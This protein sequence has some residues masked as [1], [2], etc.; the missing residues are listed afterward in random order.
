MINQTDISELYGLASQH[1]LAKVVSIASELK[2][3]H[4]LQEKILSLNEFAKYCGLHKEATLSFLK[5]LDAHDIIQLL[6]E[7][8]VKEGRLCKYLEHIRAPHLLNSYQT[9]SNLS[10]SLQSNLECY[11]IEMGL[12]FSQ[13]AAAYPDPNFEYWKK[14]SAEDWLIPSLMSTYDFSK[15]SSLCCLVDDIYS[16]TQILKCN[17][18]QQGFLLKQN[19]NNIKN[20]ELHFERISFIEGNMENFIPSQ[21]EALLI[22]RGFLNINKD[23][24][25]NILSHLASQCRTSTL[26]IVDFFMPT[27]QHID[28]KISSIAAL[29]ILTCLG[30]TLRT[31]EEWI[32]LFNASPYRCKKFDKLPSSGQLKTVLPMFLYE[33]IIT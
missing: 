26:I 24:I 11:S 23:K 13:H 21:C 17:P 18:Q 25:L 27:S 32:E 5:V 15:F 14:K 3:D 22:C 1:I 29:N 9:I 6:P 12:N 2:I 7:N 10:H 31:E 16:L 8:Q 4:L 20:V 30:G 19:I 33:G 28:Y